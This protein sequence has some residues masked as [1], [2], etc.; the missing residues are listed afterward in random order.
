MSVLLDLIVHMAVK[1]EEQNA[2]LSGKKPVST[3]GSFPNFPSLLRLGS[4][5][6]GTQISVIPKVFT[7]YSIYMSI[8]FIKILNFTF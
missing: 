3:V 7:L 8:F 2:Y 1:T 6:S 4:S 5:F